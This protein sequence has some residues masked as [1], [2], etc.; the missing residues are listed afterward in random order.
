MINFATHSQF[1]YEMIGEF[2]GNVGW[3]HP[4]RIIESTE[5]ILVLEGE[6][7]IEEAGVQY[8]LGTNEIIILEPGLKHRG[9]RPSTQPTAFYWFHFHTDLSLPFKT[10]R[11]GECFEVKKQL[12]RLLH[13]T[14][15]PGYTPEYIDAT[16]YI[17]FEELSRLQAQPTSSNSVLVSSIKEFVRNNILNDPTVGEISERFGYNPDYIGKLFRTTEGIGLKEYIA[18]SKM[19]RAKDMLLTT[20]KTVKQIALELSFAEENHFLK[21]FRYHEGVTP[22]AYRKKYC[23]THQNNK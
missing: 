10:Y 4:E 12:K 18:A 19:K 15:T 5:V 20:T 7:C 13:I 11:A 6:V 16:A 21:F 1:A 9:F 14:N 17:C 22:T 23:N 8:T 3:I 2:R